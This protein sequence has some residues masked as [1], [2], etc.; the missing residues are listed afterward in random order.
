MK[1]KLLLLSLL[2]SIN[3]NAKDYFNLSYLPHFP[4]PPN[5]TAPEN[6]DLEFRS[7]LKK[8]NERVE[9]SY[10][11]CPTSCFSVGA[12]YSLQNN[13]IAK[14]AETNLASYLAFNTQSKFYYITSKYSRLLSESSEAGAFINIGQE[15]L[16]ISPNAGRAT[17]SKS[18]SFIRYEVGAFV[19]LGVPL[20]L[21][22]IQRLYLD[23]GLNLSVKNNSDVVLNGETISAGN[24]EKQ[25]ILLYLGLGLSF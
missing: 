8:Y 7:K 15:Q 22:K 12:G 17:E 18:D 2:I 3:V 13:E 5:Y 6:Y 19:R 9:L 16:E 10:Q 1:F 4:F 21:L 20:Q 23:S 11:F 24:L 25:R 14:Y